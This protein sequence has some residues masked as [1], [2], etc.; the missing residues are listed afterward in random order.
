MKAQIISIINSAV[1]DFDIKWRTFEQRQD[2]VAKYAAQIEALYEKP[3]GRS[4]KPTPH[5]NPE[6]NFHED[7]ELNAAL[8]MFVRERKLK[9]VPV[10]E[11]AMRLIL[12]DLRE[13]TVEELTKAVIIACKSNYQGVFPKKEQQN[14]TNIGAA[15][16]LPEKMHY[17]GNM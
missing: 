13:F 5:V 1:E 12:L 4:K 6:D 2:A 9:R 17:Q 8:Q 10:T 11:N 16:K 15:H 14:N 3:K 7:P